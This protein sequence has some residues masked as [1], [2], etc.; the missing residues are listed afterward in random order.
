MY[1]YNIHG[2]KIRSD[3][4][5]SIP[6]HFLLKNDSSIDEDLRVEVGNVTISEAEPVAQPYLFFKKD[7]LFH[8]YK[9]VLQCRLLIS[10]LENKTKI[11]FSQLYKKIPQF[12]QKKIMDYILD[13]KFIQKGLLKIHAGAV[14][15]DG[16]GILR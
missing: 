12:N 9:A 13:L 15:Y 3:V 8:N 10:N 6:S 16:K 11:R 5:L 1:N 4:K 14:E 2:L 7:N